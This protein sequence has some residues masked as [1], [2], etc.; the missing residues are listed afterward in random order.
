VK[1]AVTGATGVIGC[2]VVPLLAKAG[3]RITIL[4]RPG[5]HR[6]GTLPSQCNIA[7]ASLFDRETLARAIAGHDAVINLA[8]HI[9]KSALGIMFRPAWHEND[10]IRREGARNI[11]DAAAGA[12]ARLLIQESFAY[13]YPDRADKWID[14]AVGLEPASYCKTILNAEAS[15]RAFARGD[16]RA[17]I[18]RFSAF[19]GP[20]ASQT[21]TLAKAVRS[22]WAGLP[23][24]RS[25]FISSVS[26][27]DAA[28]AVVAAL[29]APTGAYNVSDDCP[30]THEEFIDIVAAALNAPRPTRFPPPWT[31]LLMGSAGRTLARSIRLH[32]SKLKAVT[33]WSPGFPSI[34]EG[35][36]EA[37]RAA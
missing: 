7:E 13:A 5:S 26:H 27:D 32:N 24:K 23:G 22:G 28:S 25:S 31:A 35:L 15:A 6:N 18:L 1:I 8:T 9:P 3:H 12:G 33:G 29:A 10:R 30:V 19:Y 37:V 17:I 2:R 20:D 34:R 36:P 14:E 21:R 4:V 16:S 11:A